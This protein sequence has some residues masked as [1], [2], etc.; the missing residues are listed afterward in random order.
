[1]YVLTWQAWRSDRLALA[2]VTCG[3]AFPPLAACSLVMT[4][5]SPFL[6][7]WVWALVFGYRAMIDGRAWA[8]PV[9]GSLV[10]LGVLAKY[11][12]ALWLVSA[13]LFL[14]FTPTHRR[15]LKRPGFWVLAAVAGLSALPVLY[16]NSQ[17]DWVTFRHVAGQAGVDPSRTTG[18]R[19][20]G[21]FAYVG[22]QFALL[23]GFWFV[24]WI[25]AVIR[26]RPRA[27][28]PGGLRYLWWMSVPTFVVFAASSVRAKGQLNWPVAAYVSGAVLV[29]GWL[30]EVLRSNQPATRRAARWG[31]ALAVALGA[32]VTVLTHDTRLGTAIVAPVVEPRSVL[33]T[34]ALDPA[35]RLKGWRHLGSEL[36]ALRRQL[37]EAEGRDP[38]LVGLR[39]DLPGLLG[40][41]SAGRPQGYSIGLVLGVD[42]HSQND[43]WHPNPTGDPETFRGRTFLVV[44]AWDSSATLAPAF[45]SV[46]S[47]REVV[48]FE[49]G[50]PLARWFVCVGHG[51][52]GFPPEW[53]PSAA[54]H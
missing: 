48:Y 50:R 33:S 10:A 53:S 2:V 12:M 1:M 52:R 41:Y 38:V 31:F 46:E 16:W 21:L 13:A 34:R 44:G 54:R 26:F 9:A 4:I 24:A 19:W 25:A 40:F 3:L 35:A 36:D 6:C 32:C 29:A 14:V 51:F 17:H 45:D 28:V 18:V 47:P 7:C 37:A 43:L 23:L 5:D 15:L 42:R 11:T 27:G 8:W 49:N 22:G 20:Y 30:S 39:W